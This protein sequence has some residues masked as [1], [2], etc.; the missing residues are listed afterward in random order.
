[1]FAEA[2]APSLVASRRGR[3]HQALSSLALSAMSGLA[4]PDLI[5]PCLDSHAP[6]IR[7]MPGPVWSCLTSSGSPH[8][9]LS[10]DA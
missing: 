10:K 1:M 8:R 5:Q 3:S 7:A 6:P 2:A 4:A 9:T